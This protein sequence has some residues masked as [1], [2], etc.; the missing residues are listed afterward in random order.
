[1]SVYSCAKYAS[2]YD[3]IVLSISYSFSPIQRRLIWFSVAASQRP[4]PVSYTHLDVYKRQVM[5][6]LL[7]ASIEAIGAREIL[8][9]RGNPTVE[10]EV[11]LE[12]LSLIHI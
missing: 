5:R 1:M 12:D 8:D 11:V 7:V 10:V 6:S 4:A 2:Q 3:G 9:S